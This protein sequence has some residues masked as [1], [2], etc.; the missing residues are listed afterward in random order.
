MEKNDRLVQL[1]AASWSPVIRL[2]AAA[3]TAWILS[4]TWAHR[5]EVKV[6]VQLPYN[7]GGAENARQIDR[8]LGPAV[9]IS[10]ADGTASPPSRSALAAHGG[11]AVL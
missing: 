10:W 2:I 7:G 8:G 11:T 6:G 4:G 3:S 1:P 5:Q 9:A